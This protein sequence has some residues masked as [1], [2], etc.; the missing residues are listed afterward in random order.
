MIQN[1][2]NKVKKSNNNSRKRSVDEILDSLG[3][4]DI[5]DNCKY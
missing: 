4:I 3:P 2:Q 5:D 1:E